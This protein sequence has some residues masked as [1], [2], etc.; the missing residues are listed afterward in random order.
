VNLEPVPRERCLDEVPIERKRVSL[1]HHRAPSTAQAPRSGA[2]GVWDKRHEDALR[3]EQSGKPLEGSARCSQ[4]LQNM[5]RKDGIEAASRD[6]IQRL[7][8]MENFDSKSCATVGSSPG[9]NVESECLVASGV[10]LQ[11]PVTPRA[12]EIEDPSART[13]LMED[14]D[15]FRK[16]LVGAAEI[17]SNKRSQLLRVRKVRGQ[18]R[19]LVPTAI[20]Q[21]VSPHR[22]LGP[23]KQQMAHGTAAK[24]KQSVL[25]QRHRCIFRVAVRTRAITFQCVRAQYADD[26]A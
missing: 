5:I 6:S 26:E 20:I 9:R 25:P 14:R 13:D 7:V 22:I 18:P 16:V 4:V 2:I 10:E 23:P 15:L 3:T 1:A 17:P 8:G 12:S 11:Y 24:L 21:G 19:L